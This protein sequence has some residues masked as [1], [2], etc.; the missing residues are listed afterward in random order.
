MRIDPHVHCRDGK[1]SY[2]ETIAHVFDL[3]DEQGVDII[4]DMPNTD[5]P[6]LGPADVEARLKLVP[7]HAR[8]RYRLYMGATADKKQLSA[9]ADMVRDSKSVIGLKLYAGKSIG[10]LAV[11]DEAQQKQVYEHLVSAG[12][13]GMLAVHCEKKALTTSAFN[14]DNPYTHSLARPIE[15]ETASITDQVRFAK[16]AGFQGKLHICHV[17]SASSVA[18]VE[19]A[20][21][22]LNITCGVTPHHLL[23]SVERARRPDGLLYK[24]NPPLRDPSETMALRDALKQGSIDWIE[25]D[26]APHP[27]SEKLYPPHASG[28]PS[29]CLYR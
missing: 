14:P 16:T 23:W 28:Y 22:D 26:H 2:K 25:T 11:I 15:A 5:P 17:S 21:N 13:Q 24:V 10:N 18:L 4:F 1:Q 9:A 6:I 3:C 12:F 29:L 20:R 8:A 19:A 7:E 27:V